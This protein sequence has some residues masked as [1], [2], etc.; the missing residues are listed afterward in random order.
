[1]LNISMAW[2]VIVSALLMIYNIEFARASGGK[3]HYPE[4]SSWPPVC[5]NGKRQSPININTGSTIKRCPGTI[6][7]VDSYSK[8]PTYCGVVKSS[9]SVEV[10]CEYKPVMKGG[11]NGNTRFRVLS[12]HFHWGKP[13]EAGSEHLINGQRTP[14]EM[15]VVHYIDGKNPDHSPKSVVG[16]MIEVGGANAAFNGIV[17]KLAAGGG[18]IKGPDVPTLSKLLP[19]DWKTRYY[20]YPGS[21]TTPPCTENVQWIV[22]KTKVRISKD[23]MNA[24]YS[25]GRSMPHANFRKKHSKDIKPQEC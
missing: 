21:L 11:P 20:T 8:A 13:G 16:V 25:L 7:E 12:L 18:A 22:A 23:Q 3:Y 4:D 6:S 9:T 5:H 24:F 2:S 15:H 17:S 14:L 1:M 10:K 19:N